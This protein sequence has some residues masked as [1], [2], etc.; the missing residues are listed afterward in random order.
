MK[1]EQD[2]TVTVRLSKAEALVIFEFLAREAEAEVE[3]LRIVHPAEMNALWRIEAQL[4]TTLPEI[5]L[6]NYGDVLRD[7]RET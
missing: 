6:P 7:A 5:L 3:S 2:D 1:E 4:E